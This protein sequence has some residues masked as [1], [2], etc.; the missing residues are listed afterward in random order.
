MILL[1]CHKY[2]LNYTKKVWKKRKKLEKALK[3]PGPTRPAARIVKPDPTRARNSKTRPDPSPQKSGSKPS[4]VWIFCLL[5]LAQVAYAEKAR[6]SNKFQ[7]SLMSS[8]H[9][10]HYVISIHY[11]F[12][13]CASF[14]QILQ[15][16]NWT[17]VSPASSPLTSGVSCASPPARGSASRRA[18]TPQ[19]AGAA[20][21]HLK[22]KKENN[23]LFCVN[24][25]SI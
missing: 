3:C 6:D 13:S 10:V 24:C 20:S 18:F 19:T 25:V 11:Q 5:F 8:L 21:G 9:T 1:L 23:F 4:L 12:I 17:S 16:L 22:K 14:N 15:H 7:L 2:L